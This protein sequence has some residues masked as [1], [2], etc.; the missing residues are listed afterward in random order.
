MKICSVY[1]SLEMVTTHY[2][3][4]N[5]VTLEDQMWPDYLCLD[6]VRLHHLK[7]GCVTADSGGTVTHQN[8][9]LFAKLTALICA[10][11]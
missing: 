3:I 8:T 11:R 7:Q 9:S 4:M 5:D 1:G 10:R 2:D 6:D